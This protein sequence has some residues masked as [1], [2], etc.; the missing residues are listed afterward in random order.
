MKNIIDATLNFFSASS[1]VLPVITIPPR[2]LS[3]GQLIMYSPFSSHFLT[4]LLKSNDINSKCFMGKEQDSNLRLHP[5]GCR[6]TAA[7][8]SPFKWG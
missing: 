1:N 4:R 7:L 5:H 6:A 3:G 2:P 8:S